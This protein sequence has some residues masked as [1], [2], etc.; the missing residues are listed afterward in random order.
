MLGI[1]EVRA[2]AEAAHAGVTDK[3]GDPY[4]NHVV[5]VAEGVKPFGI[6][7][8]EMAALLHDVVEDTGWTES[9]L[10]RVGVPS[11]VV[12]TV[13]TVTNQNGVPYQE[14]IRLI[15]DDLDSTR[16]KISDNAHNSR[17]DRLARI[18]DQATRHRLH[19]K[20][21]KARDQLWLAASPEDIRMII[22]IVNPDLISE[23]DG[24]MELG[25]F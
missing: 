8:L 17:P 24:R 11:Q 25:Q 2:I 14:K 20:Y 4:I 19:L 1:D 15:T 13:M 3:I 16:L 12:R 10:L 23:L 6:D 21:L 18:T 7:K 22:E 5:A 9:L